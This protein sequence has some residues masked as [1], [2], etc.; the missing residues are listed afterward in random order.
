MATTFTPPHPAATDDPRPG[1]PSPGAGRRITPTG[2]RRGPGRRPCRL[3][4]GQIVTTQV[5]AAGLITVPGRG[6]LTT[7]TAALVVVG[8]LAVTW[9]RVRHRWLHEW[10]VTGI[11][12]LARR[13]ATGGH[14]GSTELLGLVAPHAVVRSVEWG[15]GA[16]SVLD[17]PDG[18]VALLEIGDP[19]DLLGD[20]GRSLPSPASLL[21]AETDQT[22]PVRVQLLL[23][24]MPAPTVGAGGGAA[25]VSYRQLADGRLAGWERAVLAVRVTRVW[26]WPEEAL[27]HALA[28][29]VR[30]IVRRLRPVTVRQVGEQSIRRVLAEFAHHDGRP[31]RE[32]WQA[33]RCGGLLQTSFRLRRWP[34]GDAVTT[35]LSR[36]WAVPAS[37]ITVSLHTGTQRPA[38]TGLIVRLAAATPAELSHAARQLR[39]AVA[40]DGTTVERLDG[41][42]WSGLAGTLPL[43]LPGAAPPTAGNPPL[44]LPYG[45]AGLKLGANRHGHA[46]TV[47][48]FRPE[49]TRL[50]LVGGVPVAQLVAV[51][52]MALGARVIV[53]TGRPHVWER[54]VRGVGGPDGPVPL[55]PPDR[56]VP[57]EP[58]TP[59]KPV[60]V[61]L[62]A[63]PLAGPRPG[64]TWQTTLLVRDVLTSADADALSRADLAVLR[65]LSQAEATVAGNALGL[66]DAA[67]LLTRIR[68]D[69]VAV[70][71]RRALRWALLACTPIESQLIGTAALRRAG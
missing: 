10:L 3:R 56:P 62:D 27:R 12:Y 54:F 11:G 4:A 53:Q 19:A 24:G 14:S 33:V 52:A 9:V 61:V 6:P 39:R 44:E 48:L 64:T 23:T 41:G 20:G 50:V 40:T 58:G 22:P 38:T 29:T 16:A 69:M 45:A 63:P 49:S 7:V 8:L 15:G 37:A 21:P 60:L 34:D 59:L 1:D 47:R 26:G 25:A 2:S 28:G 70:V 66:G 30:R 55:I 31:V 32:S 35:L 71:N 17:D 57:G 46:V 18:L 13:R 42:Q 43:A 68:H 65:P 36:L 51:R 67:E 5:A